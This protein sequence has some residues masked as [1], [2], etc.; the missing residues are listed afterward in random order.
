MAIFAYVDNSNLF[1][2]GQRVSAVKK[3]QPGATNIAEATANRIQDYSYKIEY[4]RLYD[5]LLNRFATTNE[6]KEGSAA[7]L[8][9][10]PP[11]GDS[12]WSYI[13]SKGFKVTTY[14]RSSSGK[15][16]MVDVGLATQIM[17][18]SYELK[19]NKMD[20]MFLIVSGDADYCPVIEDLRN[21]DFFVQVAFWNHASQMLK[22]SANIFI[23]L[24]DRI[25][26]I[27]WDESKPGV[28]KI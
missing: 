14:G 10:S 15:E 19:I 26:E 21:R 4:G 18:D 5:L 11:P 9:G 1:I 27:C 16:K 25:W 2:E 23:N 28:K 6:S 17:K 20:D 24:D 8:W 12:F 22:D 3:R 13:E 7:K